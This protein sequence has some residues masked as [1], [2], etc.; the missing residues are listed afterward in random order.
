MFSFIFSLF[1][2]CGKNTKHLY[3]LNIGQ[4]AFYCANSVLGVVGL[5]YTRDNEATV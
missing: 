5:A 1:L 3:R 2:H 4:K